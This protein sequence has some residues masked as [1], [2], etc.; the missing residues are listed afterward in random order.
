[1]V[2]G[3]QYNLNSAFCDVVGYAKNYHL[4]HHK[5]WRLPDH[6]RTKPKDCAKKLM[7]DWNVLYLELVGIFNELG[8]E[9][10]V[11]TESNS[12]IVG[13]TWDDQNSIRFD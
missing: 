2:L 6:H 3:P 13:L 9:L 1:M 8:V 12:K 10:P 7:A 11:A 5:P 4:Y